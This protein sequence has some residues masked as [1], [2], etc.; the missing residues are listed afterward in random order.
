[1]SC[2]PHTHR[3]GTNPQHWE[4]NF[5]TSYVAGE[6]HERSSW[7]GRTVILGSAAAPRSE[8]P[9]PSSP[10]GRSRSGQRASRWPR[11]AQSRSP[12][13]CARLLAQCGAL[14]FPQLLSL[15]QE[16]AV[17]QDDGASRELP[18][19]A[20]PMGCSK[21]RLNSN[22][23]AGV[24]DKWALGETPQSRLGTKRLSNLGKNCNLLK[25]TNP[26]TTHDHSFLR[27]NSGQW[28][29]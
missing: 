6:R 12:T 25:K 5:A 1:M 18:S 2:K 29:N 13:P 16:P 21:G 14:H 7:W 3:I 23:C 9:G 26:A 4:R 28:E 11:S 15:P 10:R 27:D 19:S 8:R 24:L 17:R 22:T 20:K